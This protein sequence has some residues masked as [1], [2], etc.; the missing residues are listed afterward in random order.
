MD[1]YFMSPPHPSWSLRGRANFRSRAAAEV[2]ATRARLEWLTLAEG[3]EALGGTVVVLEPPS[4][5]MTGLPYA[6]EAGHPLPPLRPGGKP[7]FILPRMKPEHRRAEKD[8][9][10]PLFETLGFETIELGVGIWEGQGDVATF[11]NTTILFWGGRT[12]RVGAQT[13]RGH[14]PGEVLEIEI[15]EPAFHGNMGLLPLDHADALF[16]CADVIEEDSLAVL[17]ARFGKDRMHLVSEDEIRL[18]AT[19]GLPVGD[20]LLAPSILPERVRKAIERSGMK[21]AEL[22]MPELCEKAGGA[23]RCLVCKFDGA[24]ESLS[25]P[26]AMRLEAQKRKIRS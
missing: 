9:W 14:F 10:R 21:V 16:V 7:R 26:E 22:S 23:S 19:N 13:A 8:V 11:D 15:R 20:T 12:D 5:E 2:D 4:A 18:Y 24:P 25:I 17:E 6:A 3:I 1:L